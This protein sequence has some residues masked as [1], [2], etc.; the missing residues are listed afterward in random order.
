MNDKAKAKLLKRLIKQ[1]ERELAKEAKLYNYPGMKYNR[2]KPV[3]GFY[4]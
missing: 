1:Q 3:K 4:K 2:G